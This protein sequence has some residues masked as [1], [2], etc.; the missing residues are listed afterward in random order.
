MRNFL[1]GPLLVAFALF[2]GCASDPGSG[3]SNDAATADQDNT[4]S[5]GGD[6][7]RD[8]A[9]DSGEAAPD[10]GPLPTGKSNLRIVAGNISS[11]NAS[12]YDAGEGIR[13]LQGLKPDVALLQELNY[14]DNTDADLNAFVTTTFGQG[15]TFYRE[16]GVQ[17]PNAV[18][19]RYPMLASGRWVD[20]QV[21]N[22]GFA[23]AKIDVPGPHDLWAV[24][25]HTLTTGSA[26]RKKEADALVAELRKVVKPGEYVV[27]GGDL[28]TDNRTE[29]CLTSFGATVVV[30]GPYPADQKGN[31][32]TSGPR[33]RPYDW[34]MVS[35][36]LAARQVPTVLGASKYDAGLVFDSRVYTPL[37]EVA[38]VKATDSA[39]TNMQHMP[40]VKDFYLAP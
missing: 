17:I 38:P 35:P 6:T 25:V 30:T 12:T 3:P 4:R 14:L 40:V 26:D 5:D 7:R 2:S 23:W 37:S 13:M 1:V 36:D 27:I 28:N 22:R 34:V 31:E 16:T 18:V 39:A 8:A 15:F 9:P 33:T 21:N 24:S 19:S 11:G 29:A 32:N 10:G 20:P